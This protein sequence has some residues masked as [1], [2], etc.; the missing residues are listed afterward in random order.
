M[1]GYVIL[2][3]AGST[4]G[5]VKDSPIYKSVYVSSL[6]GVQPESSITANAVGENF[7]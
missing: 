2:I 3:I 7:E 5:C 1:P 6:T 4:V